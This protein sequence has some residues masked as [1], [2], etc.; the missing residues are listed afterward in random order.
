MADVKQ[1]QE[2]RVSLIYMED[3]ATKLGLSVT[4]AL[5]AAARTEVEDILTNDY[6]LQLIS[7]APVARHCPTFGHASVF[8]PRNGGLFPWLK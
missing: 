5:L 7:A 8:R 3:D 4:P 2:F 6:G 1:L